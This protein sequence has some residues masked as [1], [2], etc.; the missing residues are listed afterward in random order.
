MRFSGVRARFVL[1]LLLLLAPLLLLYQL[2]GMDARLLPPSSFGLL[3]HL[4]GSIV[5]PLLTPVGA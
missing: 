1:A 5:D 3:L 2:A 4:H